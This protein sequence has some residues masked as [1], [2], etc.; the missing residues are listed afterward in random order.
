MVMRG[1]VRVD[2][3]LPIVGG[4]LVLI[5]EGGDVFIAFG[6]EGGAGV[7][8][9]D[10]RGVRAGSEAEVDCGDHDSGDEVG[11]DEMARVEIRR[12]C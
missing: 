8:D 2:L 7:D 1:E 4:G 9:V 5:G 3:L 12:A 6:S 11:V 10:L